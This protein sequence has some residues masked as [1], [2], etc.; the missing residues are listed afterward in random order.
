MGNAVTWMASRSLFSC[1]LVPYVTLAPSHCVT[2]AALCTS[3]W[4]SVLHTGEMQ[5]SQADLAL[6]KHRDSF[7]QECARL[8]P[9]IDDHKWDC[10]VVFRANSSYRQEICIEGKSV[11]NLE[12]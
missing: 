9:D 3:L 6:S 2:E 8:L 7:H 10:T 4:F 1:A 12:C 11:V 5:S